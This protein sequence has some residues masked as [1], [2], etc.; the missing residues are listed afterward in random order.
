MQGARL[1]APLHPAG[2]AGVAQKTVAIA[3]PRTQGPKAR[4]GR[5]PSG[6]AQPAWQGGGRP[7][8]EEALRGRPWKR[9]RGLAVTPR[10]TSG[11]GPSFHFPV[12]GGRSGRRAARKGSSPAAGRR[13]S[14]AFSAPDGGGGGRRAG[15]VGPGGALRGALP[16]GPGDPRRRDCGTPARGGGEGGRCGRPGGGREGRTRVAAEGAIFEASV[17]LRR[18]TSTSLNPSYPFRLLQPLLVQEGNGSR[19]VRTGVT[20]AVGRSRVLS[21]G[22]PVGRTPGRPQAEAELRPPVGPALGVPCAWIPYALGL[23]PN[24]PRDLSK[25]YTV[26]DRN[27]RHRT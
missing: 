26:K 3:A 19:A 16:W 12:S 9:G 11:P 1:S 21:A 4:G 22:P 10:S 13:A 27:R 20:C 2:R 6:G 23:R 15:G 25:E 17:A 8:G 7:V 24:H 14:L 18:E 5:G